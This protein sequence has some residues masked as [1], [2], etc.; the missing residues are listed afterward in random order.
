MK[1]NL[2]KFI[3]IWWLIGAPIIFAPIVPASTLSDINHRILAVILSVFA[4]IMLA[5]AS[6]K[7]NVI[8]RWFCWTD[9]LNDKQREALFSGRLKEYRMNYKDEFYFVRV[10]PYVFRFISLSFVVMMASSMI[11]NEDL[12]GSLIILLISSI[13]SGIAFYFLGIC[14]LIL[15]LIPIYN[16]NANKHKTYKE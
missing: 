2:H 1:I 4:L 8:K 16:G 12:M 9:A 13:L 14:L 5:P 10:K 6:T 11:Q 15:A 7:F 3:A